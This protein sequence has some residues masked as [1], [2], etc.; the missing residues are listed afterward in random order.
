V[1]PWNGTDPLPDKLIEQIRERRL[2]SGET[3]PFEGCPFVGLAAFR[4]DQAHLFFGRQK[5]TLDALACFFDIRPGRPAVRW[6]E[7]NGNS[8]S[9]KSSLMQAGFLPLID[10]GWLWRPGRR[11]ENWTRIGPR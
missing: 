1:T 3:V 11:Y 5:E 2:V 9:G 6:L 4:T 8:G 7:I 10:K